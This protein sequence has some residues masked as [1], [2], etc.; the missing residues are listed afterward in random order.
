M[1]AGG[2]GNS[3]K[4]YCPNGPS[5]ETISGLWAGARG[6]ASRK[7]KKKTNNKEWSNG[8]STIVDIG[9]HTHCVDHVAKG[10]SQELS[11]TYCFFDCSRV[12]KA[13][14][15]LPFFP[16]FIGLDSKILL[17]PEYEFLFIRCLHLTH[18]QNIYP[19][20]W[21]GFYRCFLSDPQKWCNGSALSVRAPR[22]VQR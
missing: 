2:E 16:N 9:D 15:H 19:K 4:C 12:S 14:G 18:T 7:E 3:A 21:I 6:G 20:D 11:L 22:K 17:C 5:E 8:I 13:P 1:T 10:L